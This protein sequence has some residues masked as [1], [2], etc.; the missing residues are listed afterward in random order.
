MISR[1]NLSLLIFTA[2]FFVKGYTQPPPQDSMN[3]KTVIARESIAKKSKFYQWMWG[4][5]RRKEW[6][7][8]V[9]APYLW[10][11]SAGGMRVYEKGGGN[12]SKSLHLRDA[13]GKEYNLH[14]INKSRDDVVPPEFKKTFVDDLIQDNISMS[15]PYAALGL[16]VMQEK[17]GIYHPVPKLVWLPRQ[18]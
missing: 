2:F 17:A 1:T 16:H 10:L 3:R 8:P 6:A 12:E 15:H 7:L 5:N 14:S 4:R 11:D 13:K 18:A 9:Q